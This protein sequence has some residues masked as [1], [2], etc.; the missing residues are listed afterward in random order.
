ME[1]NRCCCRRCCQ[2][3]SRHSQIV[4]CRNYTPRT[5]IFSSRSRRLSTIHF[6]LGFISSPI[7][8]VVY[9][10]ANTRDRR[11]YERHSCQHFA[12]AIYLG[13]YS[14]YIFYIVSEFHDVYIKA[15]HGFNSPEGRV[16]RPVYY[17]N[18]IDL[19][20]VSNMAALWT[21]Q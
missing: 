11:L 20:T 13:N 18:L 12:R 4:G 16:S 6:M 8:R 17:L 3:P 19:Y 15:Q 1:A 7:P 5:V 10:P 21:S 9:N 14:Y 2:N